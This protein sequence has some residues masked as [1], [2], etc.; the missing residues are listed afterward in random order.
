[1]SEQEVIHSWGGDLDFDTEIDHLKDLIKN[2]QRKQKAYYAILLTQLAQSCRISEAVDALTKWAKSKKPVDVVEVKVRKRK[3]TYWRDVFIPKSIMEDA[4]SI[5]RIL[6][7]FDFTDN[8]IDNVKHFAAYHLYNTHA[9]RHAGITQQGMQ[10]V[11]AQVIA[12]GTGHKKLQHIQLYT[13]KA[14][15]RKVLREMANRA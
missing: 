1:M 6:N 12:R 2:S 14:A 7:K 8:L 11:P 15:A 9:L 13:E 3:D 4:K 5:K 10:N